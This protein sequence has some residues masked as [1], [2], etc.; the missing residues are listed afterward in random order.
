LQGNGQLTKGLFKD[1]LT[2]FVAAA[3]N[4]FTSEDF[5]NLQRVLKAISDYC[6]PKLSKEE[7]EDMKVSHNRNLEELLDLISSK[8][9]KRVFNTIIREIRYKLSKLPKTIKDKTEIAKQV[10]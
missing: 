3:Q 1:A 5:L 4:Y 8:D 7:I 9:D 2:D 10:N 6:I